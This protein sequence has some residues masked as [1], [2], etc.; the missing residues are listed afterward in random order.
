MACLLAWVATDV[1]LLAAPPADDHATARSPEAELL[2]LY[3]VDAKRLAEFN[4]GRPV[5]EDELDPLLRMPVAARRFTL[6]EFK[7][8]QRSDLPDA[9]DLK[10][11]RD[12]RGRIYRFAGRVKRVEIERLPAE[13]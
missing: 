12:D 10:D 1:I 7:Q 13:L 2:A 5:A 4:D 11:T 8:W 6:G 9:A 3:G